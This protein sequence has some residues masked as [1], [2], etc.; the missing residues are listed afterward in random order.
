MPY[1]DADID[2]WM[3]RPTHRDAE[4]LGDALR[5][6]EARIVR[7]YTKL[8]QDS[9]LAYE[10]ADADRPRYVHLHTYRPDPADAAVSAGLKE[11]MKLAIADA[12]VW[13][14]E[15]WAE[16]EPL[17]R[18]EAGKAKT[19]SF[20]PEAHDQLPSSVDVWLAP[21]DLRAPCYTL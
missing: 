7:R 20:R 14:L 16:L 6:A 10:L 8:G 13:L 11:A 3:I 18:D 5:V 9:A 4:H 2:A 21:F 19:R 1:F 15:Q 12:A 17:V